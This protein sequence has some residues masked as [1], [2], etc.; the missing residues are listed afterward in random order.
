MSADRVTDGEA[1]SPSLVG[2]LESVCDRFE[3]AWRDGDRP[4]L[5]EF[6]EGRVDGPDLLR[7][8]LV[9]E[10]LYRMRSGERPRADEYRARFPGH[11][12]TIE[13]ALAAVKD[14]EDVGTLFQSEQA[15][16]APTHPDDPAREESAERHVVDALSRA[17]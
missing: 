4:S 14:G 9:I 1:L 16:D 6:W 17:G 8:L 12:S 10:L 13:G 7:E 5:E 3:D 2:R 15:A 11:D